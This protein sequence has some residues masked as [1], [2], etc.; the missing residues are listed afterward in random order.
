MDIFI[1]NYEGMVEV[2]T[3]ADNGVHE[4]LSFRNYSDYIEAVN[5]I[6]SSFKEVLIKQLEYSARQIKT[7]I[8]RLDYSNE[9]FIE[10]YCENT[11]R[12]KEYTVWG[13]KN[14]HC[15]NVNITRCD[16]I[17]NIKVEDFKGDKKREYY[18]NKRG[19]KIDVSFLWFIIDDFLECYMIYLLFY[20]KEY[21]KYINKDM[22]IMKK[23]ARSRLVDNHLRILDIKESTD[24]YVCNANNPDILPY[25]ILNEFL[26]LGYNIDDIENNQLEVVKMRAILAIEFMERLIGKYKVDRYYFINDENEMNIELEDMSNSERFTVDIRTLKCNLLDHKIELEFGDV[27]PHNKWLSLYKLGILNGFY[28]IDYPLLNLAFK[29]ELYS[30]KF[31]CTRDFYKLLHRFETLGY[32]IEILEDN[33]IKATNKEHSVMYI[34]T[35]MA[36]LLKGSLYTYI[37]NES[38]IY[39][40]FENIVA[41]TLDLHNIIGT[42]E[43]NAGTLTNLFRNSVLSKLDMGDCFIGNIDEHDYDSLFKGSRIGNL[44]NYINNI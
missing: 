13:L 42:S 44:V 19:H 12:F 21:K 24:I 43:V 22:F 9:K 28:C 7:Y 33:L 37:P 39:G 14:S 26:D 4:Y 5:A 31:I 20:S 30:V 40:A 15:L 8:D 10:V 23:F 17:K 25:K 3:C 27:E 2:F 11:Q 6:G 18:Y 38:I 16:N 1:E 35:N 29:K 41:N 34:L 36:L 32:N